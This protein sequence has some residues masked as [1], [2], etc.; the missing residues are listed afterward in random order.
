[1]RRIPAV[2]GAVAMLGACSAPT[3][4][5]GIDLTQPVPPRP[6][7]LELLQ[8][9]EITAILD[10]SVRKDCGGESE[11]NTASC[12][13]LRTAFVDRI[14]E[15]ASQSF[16]DLSHMPLVTLARRAQ[17]GDKQAQLELGLRFEE[18]RGVA[19]NLDNAR[20][21]YSRAATTTGGDIAV[22]VPGVGD[23]P[24]RVTWVNTGPVMPGL[25]AARERLNALRARMTE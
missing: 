9:P 3:H 14:A 19:R 10:A 1:M 7:T 12:E 21:L 15:P 18:G 22:Y 23:S 17:L 11:A 24:G 8:D 2:A 6:S 4:Y 16:G 25:S 20:A 13:A 5:F